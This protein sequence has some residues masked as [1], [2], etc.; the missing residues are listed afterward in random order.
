M[1][2]SKKIDWLIRPAIEEDIPDMVAL[3][4]KFKEVVS[5]YSLLPIQ[6]K[7]YLSEI[8]V[9]VNPST[10]GIGGFVHYIY[11]KNESAWAYLDYI[12]I[13]PRDLVYQFC[14]SGKGTIFIGQIMG[15]PGTGIQRLVVD[16]LKNFNPDITEIWDWLSV[17]SPVYDFYESVGLSFK[18]SLD[19]RFFNPYKG[20][21]STFRLG[22][23][24]QEE[25]IDL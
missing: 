22:K 15:P 8:E 2:T 1:S 6:L 3:S 19:Y 20:D 10:G 5:P 9:V 17:K 7:V 13:M 21:Y 12:R 16:H 4:T 11:E 14:N 25:D 18:E 23:W 24:I